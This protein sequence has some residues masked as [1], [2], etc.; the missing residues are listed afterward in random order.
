[1]LLH[2]LGHIQSDEGLRRVEQVGGQLFDQLGL[3]YAGGADKDEGHRLAL[4]ADAHTAPPDGG[5][6]GVDRLILTDDVLL[7]PLLQLGQALILWLLDAAGGDVGPQLDDVGQML[8][9]QGGVGAASS[10]PF[11]CSSRSS[12]LRMAA[13][14]A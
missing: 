1:M 10:C 8:Q 6:D 13:S 12:W 7:Q 3:A 9:R 2:K 4:G 11:S 5:G 14:R